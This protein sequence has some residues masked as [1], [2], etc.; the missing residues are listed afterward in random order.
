M[1]DKYIENL[2]LEE[3]NNLE[4]KLRKKK[5]Q[6]LEAS[7]KEKIETISDLFSQI[8]CTSVGENKQIVIR[9]DINGNAVLISPDET[10]YT[11]IYIAPEDDIW[12][13]E[14]ELVSYDY[15]M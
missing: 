11:S 6:C 5:M 10:L 3:I 14:E 1:F 13:E 15:T 4:Q 8:A 9:L 7:F 12:S 2:S